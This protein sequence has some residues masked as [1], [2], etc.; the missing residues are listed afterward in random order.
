MKAVPTAFVTGG[1]E[2]I[3]AATVHSLAA[4]GYRVYF[5]DI[6]QSKG[7]S[8]LDILK[9]EGIDAVFLKLDVGDIDGW[10]DAS[11][12]L[13]RDGIT[14][15]VLVNNA[16][17]ADPFMQ[18]PSAS[19]EAWKRV[20]DT[21]LSGMFLA[22]NFI[23]PLMEEGSSIVNIASTR[24]YQSEKNTLSYSA[25]KGG[26]VALTHSLSVTLSERRIRVNSISPGWI[27]TSRWH[28]PQGISNYNALDHKQHPSGRI[29][30]PEDVAN[31]VL[32]LASSRGEW[33]NGENIVI[34]GGMTRRMIYFDKEVLEE[35]IFQLTGDKAFASEIM[36]E[37][38]R[39]K[40]TSVSKMGP[41]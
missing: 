24:A 11:N 3:G 22:S 20:L 4:E 2:G 23:V 27:D 9:K 31:L 38:F 21:N 37:A 33:I 15:N 40:K 13:S 26:V 30:K 28:I 10:R 14:F 6:D 41:E 34:D 17:I 12:E 7:K 16:G 25:S 18:F 36:E 39:R 1:A 8:R 32:F 19:E 35:A 29:G 5:C